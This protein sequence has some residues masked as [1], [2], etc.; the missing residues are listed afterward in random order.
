MTDAKA[1]WRV[2]RTLREDVRELRGQLDITT[3]RLRELETRTPHARQLAHEAD[4]AAAELAASGYDDT[5]EDQAPV[6]TDRHGASCLC[7]YCYDEPDE[8]DTPEYHDPERDDQGGVPECRITVA[9]RE[10]S[11]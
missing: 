1:L 11:S 9:G 7:P 6:G 2:V 8:Y 4:L 10:G 3:G 5:Y